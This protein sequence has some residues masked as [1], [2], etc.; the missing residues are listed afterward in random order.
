MRGPF[1]NPSCGLSFMEKM[2]MSM[3][4]IGWKTDIE[5]QEL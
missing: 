2:I 4:V 1:P 3:D 5:H